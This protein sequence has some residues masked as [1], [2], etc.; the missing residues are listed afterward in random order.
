ML[1]SLAPKGNASRLFLRLSRR[2]V[3]WAGVCLVGAAV[4]VVVNFLVPEGAFMRIMAVATA[5]AAITWMMIVLVPCGPQGPRAR[6]T[7]VPRTPPPLDE[8]P[9]RGFPGAAGGADDT[10]GRHPAG[11]LRAAV[12][13]VVL[14][15]GYRLKRRAAT[16]DSASSPAPAAAKISASDK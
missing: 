7:A 4:I 13:L 6:H 10:A 3:P 1:Q 5:A 14:Y 11:G 16:S 12:W 15:A 8:L 2:R 9:V